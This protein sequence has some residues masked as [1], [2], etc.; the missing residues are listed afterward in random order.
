MRLLIVTQVVDKNDPVLGFFHRWIEEFAKHTERV[1]VICLSE[2]VH[3][4]PQNVSV[5]SLGKERG[6]AGKFIYAFRF[7]RLAWKL[8]H[9][10]DTVF[11]HMNEEYLLLGGVLWRL[12]GKPA[13]LWR[14][15]YAG[16]IL[17]VIAALLATSV[18]YTSKHSFTARFKKAVRMPV[19]VETALFS[20]YRH[21]TKPPRTALHLS[22]ISPSKRIE[23]FVEALGILRAKGV[24]FSAT[25]VGSAL[26]EDETY[27]ESLVRQAERLG[28]SEHLAFAPGVSHVET[29]AIFGRHQVSVNCAESGMLDK[30]LFEAAAAGS[31]V[32]ASSKDW[33]EFME[34]AS[35]RFADAQELARALELAFERPDTGALDRQDRV[36]KE[37]SL[38]GVIA[39]ILAA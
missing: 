4:L 23:L 19:G 20:A 12:L 34:D 5:Y 29:A 35:I 36:V 37:H 30:T 16:S 13:G 25:I 14:N 3:S 6:R 2:G 18:F 28:L 26:P 27:R 15:H 22:R 21:S 10:Y 32:L 17:T 31:L 39:R 11:V 9:E 33:A 1:T 8:R 24:E 7:M 38:S